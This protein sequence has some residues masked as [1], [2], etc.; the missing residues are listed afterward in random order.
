MENPDLRGPLG[1]VRASRNWLF[2]S[3]IV[4]KFVKTLFT[5]CEKKKYRSWISE[6]WNICSWVRELRYIR[7][8]WFDKITYTKWRNPQFLRLRTIYIVESSLMEG[9]R[10]QKP[11]QPQFRLPSPLAPNWGLVGEGRYWNQPKFRVFVNFLGLAVFIH[12][13][14]YTSRWTIRLKYFSV[15]QY[16]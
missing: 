10:K 3:K 1:G 12:R 2:F 6:K 8:S 5:I 16:K 11:A 9:E 14:N 7:D 15:Y 13:T 4:R